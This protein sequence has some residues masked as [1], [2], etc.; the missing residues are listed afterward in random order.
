M[1]I[2]KRI[3]DFL[4]GRPIASESTG[5]FIEPEDL[6]ELLRQVGPLRAT[7]VLIKDGRNPDALEAVEILTRTDGFDIHIRQTDGTTTEFKHIPAECLRLPYAKPAVKRDARF[8]QGETDR[9]SILSVPVEN[10]PCSE[11]CRKRVT[12]ETYESQVN[13]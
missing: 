12:R 2:I 11:C 5:M 7:P 10:C 13:R 4:E 8:T 9:H 1:N 3:R 6:R